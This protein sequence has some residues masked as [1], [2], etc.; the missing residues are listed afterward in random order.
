MENRI[1]DAARAVFIE[2]G[3]AETSMS[4]IAAKAGINRP[5]LHYYFR[6]KDKMFQAVFG[7]IVSSV[8]PKVFDAIMHKEKSVAERTECIIDAYYSL[9]INTPQL[10]L[11]MLRELNR[12]PEMLIKTILGL[13]V[14]DT[15]RK[16]ISSLQEEMDEGKLKKVPL[17]FI[18]FN[19]YSLLT[20]PFLTIDISRKVFEN[21]DDTLRESLTEWKKNIVFQMENLL[22]NQEQV[23]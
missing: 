22:K 8:I 7:S 10:P 20:F 2:K 12:D 5:A 11:F 14:A 18:F 16:A 19:F 9:F 3:Y 17:Q 13:N 1:I 6:T 21:N 15:M 4:E 23:S